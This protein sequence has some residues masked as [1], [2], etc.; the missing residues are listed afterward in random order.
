MYSYRCLCIL[1]HCYPDWGFSVLFPQLQGK[2]QGI[3]S[4][5]RARPA[6][7]QSCCV[8]LCIVCFVSF[9]VLFVCKCVL[10]YC[11]RVTTQLQLTNISISKYL[12][13][14]FRA[15]HEAERCS[16]NVLNLCLLNC[17]VLK[18]SVSLIICYDMLSWWV[19][20]EIAVMKLHKRLENMKSPGESEGRGRYSIWTS[21]IIDDY[22]VDLLVNLQGG[23]YCKLEAIDV[24]V[25]TTTWFVT[26]SRMVIWDLAG[27]SQSRYSVGKKCIII[28][29]PEI[30]LRA[31]SI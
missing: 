4:Q 6:L 16:V 28:L 13:R 29:W 2:C 30:Q 24:F 25:M 26:L 31:R 3:T 7:F 22:A 20:P 18:R 11:H 9:C 12:H 1:R 17:V 19:R 21:A 27:N 15:C 23:R 14:R 5:D 10:Y 8:V